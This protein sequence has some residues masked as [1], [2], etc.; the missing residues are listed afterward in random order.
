MFHTSLSLSLADLRYRCRTGGCGAEGGPLA[1]GAEDDP[2]LPQR[3]GPGLHP[4][5][6]G[7]TG[8]LRDHS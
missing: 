2:P 7:R 3:Q 1:V 5:L 8:V 4:E 6:E